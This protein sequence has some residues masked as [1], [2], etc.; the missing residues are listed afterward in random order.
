M[1]KNLKYFFWWLSGGDIQYIERSSSKS[2]EHFLLIGIGGLSIIL[3]MILS[4]NYAFKEIFDIGAISILP[5]VILTAVVSAIYWL[6]II[7]LE[8]HTLPYKKEGGSVRTSLVVRFFVIV[9]FAF[10][11]SK[12]FETYLFGDLVNDQ[13]SIVKEECQAQP[14]GALVSGKFFKTRIEAL[15]MNYPIIWL[16]TLIIIALFL[17]PIRKKFQLRRHQEYFNL[18]RISEKSLV[19]LEYR[20]FIVEYNRIFSKYDENLNANGLDKV[21][22]KAR[23]YKDT[24][25]N[26]HRLRLSES[27][28]HDEFINDLPN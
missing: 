13:V 8:P 9:L 2:K 4:F 10:F 17:F 25:F 3:I 24:P 6:N 18:K 7:S 12:V 14:E 26:T 20:K 27:S 22:F 1:K 21:R 28:S 5:A 19:S 23:P 11:V 16:M 15:N